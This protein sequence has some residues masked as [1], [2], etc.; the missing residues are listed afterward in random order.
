MIRLLA[1]TITFLTVC[2]GIRAQAA[3]SVR[4]LNVQSAYQFGFGGTN[5]L[6][7]YLSQEKFK[8][9]GLTL[10]LTSEYQKSASPW[11]T[12]LQH[13]LNFAS[14][15]DR[16]DTCNELQGDYTFLFGRYYAW[17]F[18][19]LTVKA[20]GVGGAN[21]GV[22]YNTSN[23]N[24]PAQAR[25]SVQLMPS[26]IATYDFRLFKLPLKARYEVELPL[27]GVMFSPNYGQSYYEIFSKG[28]YDHNIVP[29]TFV[30]AP[31]IRQMLSL[32]YAI[33]HFATLRIGYLGYYQQAEVNNLKS[34]IFNN[35]L[36]VG[37]VREIG[38]IRK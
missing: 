27:A 26:G 28:N 31:N 30:S 3:D 19:R 7:T 17:R 10:L 4:S 25:L 18:N 29:T 12:L 24:N 9:G 6:D 37:I 2:L 33:P 23:S 1:I 13:E 36:M 20:G 5:V 16:A 34:H 35:R 21:I 15:D 32:E 38:I 8:G 14:V 22:I 11:S